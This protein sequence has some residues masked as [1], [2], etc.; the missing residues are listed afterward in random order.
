LTGF[1]YAQPFL[2]STL[3]NH[4]DSSGADAK[5]NAGYALIGAYVLIFFGAAVRIAIIAEF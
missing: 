1:T 5:E 2:I 3:I 4:V